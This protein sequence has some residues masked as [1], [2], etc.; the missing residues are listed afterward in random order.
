MT[1]IILNGDDKAIEE[2]K[3]YAFSF[4][5]LDVDVQDDFDDGDD[6]TEAQIAESIAQGVKAIKEG[7]IKHRKLTAQEVI[8]ELNL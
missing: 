5:T 8:K 6:R 7:K 2:V 1:T 4:K 3:K